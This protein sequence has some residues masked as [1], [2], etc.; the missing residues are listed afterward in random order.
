MS[1]DIQKQGFVANTRPPSRAGNASAAAEKARKRREIVALL[2]T[3]GPG[4]LW[5]LV[6]M[7]GPLISVFYFSTLNWGDFLAPQQFVGLQNFV[8][9]FQDASFW[10][11][12]KI[13]LIQMCITLPLMILCAFLLGYYLSLRPRGYRLLSIICFTPSLLSASARAMMFT[14]VYSPNGIINSILTAVGLGSWT[15]IWLAESS[16]ALGTLIAVDLWSGIGFTAVIFAARLSSVPPELYEAAD[17][18][19]ANQWQKIWRITYPITRDF[20]GVI[21][22]LQFLWTLLGSAQNVLLLT[23][24]GPGNTTTTLGYY[25]YNEAFFTSHLG[26]S[27]AVGVVLFIL[28]LLGML[29]IRTVFKPSY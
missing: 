12:V 4:L 2:L 5:F 26:Y 25:L 15:H 28:G 10:N 6:F 8:Q 1:A 17:I 24:G 21:T 14:G 18:D 29:L 7:V 22:M 16:T 27:Q 23:Q 9:L 19:G 3:T 13:S 11:A 20:V